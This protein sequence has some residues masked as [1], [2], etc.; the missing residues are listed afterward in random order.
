MSESTEQLPWFC[1]RSQPRRE[2]IAW[3]QLSILPGVTVMFPRARY[4]RKGAK[5]KRLITEAIFPNYLFAQFDPKQSARAVGYAKGVSYIVKKGD[6]FANV[7]ASVIAELDE[8]TDEG[9]FEMPPAP[10]KM[11]D[12]IKVVA[13]I[14]EGSEAEIVGLVPAKDRVRILLDLLG[15]ATVVDIHTDEVDRPSSHPLQ[16]G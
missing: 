4:V 13:G 12:E 2:R 7:P 3:S 15:R 14:F 6:A 11:G 1:I 5:G 8:L 10:L 9:I 16:S